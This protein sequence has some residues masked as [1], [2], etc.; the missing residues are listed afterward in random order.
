MIKHEARSL[1]IGG[2]FIAD[3]YQMFSG[4]EVAQSNLYKIALG[5]TGRIWL[6]STADNIY[7]Q[8]GPN[9]E[10]FG[11]ALLE[12][13]L[14]NGCD[15]VKLK[16]AWHTES[17][18]L[19]VDTGVDIRDQNL[20]IGVIG[21]KRGYDNGRAVIEDIIWFDKEPVYGTFDR[22]DKLAD[23]LSHERKEVLYYHKQ[24]MGGS[25]CGPVNYKEYHVEAY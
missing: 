16:G 18:S 3:Y 4:Q 11:G 9:S 8:G 2:K 14:E 20:T 23:K 6:Y 5:K 24:S 13:K 12:F 15:S 25:C 17:T 7:V 19:F 10:G 22:V 1:Q 21:R